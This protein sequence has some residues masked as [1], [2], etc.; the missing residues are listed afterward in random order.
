MATKADILIEKR[1]TV[2]VIQPLTREGTGWVR[3]N[4][5]FE[6]WQVVGSGICAE[7]RM[8]EDVAAGVRGSGLTV[9]IK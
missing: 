2:A 3:K 6:P 5:H 4:V 7:P 1:G 9:Q 8:M